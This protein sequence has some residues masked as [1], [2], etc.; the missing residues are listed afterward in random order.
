M[1][2]YFLNNPVARRVG[3]CSVRAVSLA[4]DISWEDAYALLAAAGYAMGDMPSSNEVITAVLRQHGFYRKAV[5]DDCPDC[6][7]VA[8]FCE[9]NPHGTFVLFTSGHVVTAIDGDI[10]D[11]WDS[12]DE[13]PMFYC[14]RK[15]EF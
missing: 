12:S 7:T 4:L 6:Y 14:Y 13:T 10:Y 5:K 2:K 15:D 8:D 1:W 11:V 3:D 9:E